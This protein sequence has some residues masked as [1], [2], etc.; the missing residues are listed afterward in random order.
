MV[1]MWSAASNVPRAERQRREVGQRIQAA[2]IPGGIAHR[3]V[4]AAIALARE[5]VRV[6]SFARARIQHPRARRQPAR[7]RRHGVLDFGFEMQNVPP[8]RPRQAVRERRVSHRRRASIITV[9]PA[10]AG[11]FRRGER[12]RRRHQREIRQVFGQPRARAFAHA[13]HAPRHGVERRRQ[14]ARQAGR[15]VAQRKILAPHHFEAARGPAAFPGRGRGN[16]TGGAARPRRSTPGPAAGTA[17]EAA[18]GTCTTS[19]PSGASRSCAGGQV[20]ARVVEMLQHVEHGDAGEAS[21]AEAA[22]V[23]AWPQ[24][25]GTLLPAPGDGRRLARKIQAHHAEAALPHHSQKQA[26]AAAHVE[27]RAARG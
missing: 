1:T 2:V 20:G 14:A 16:R 26:A 21:G 12:Q 10:P 18:L 24:T 8:Q 7:E 4:H 5:V 22:H 11:R 17:S 6:L 9:D 23:P 27:Q 19:R 15:I 3:Q 13:P 25:A